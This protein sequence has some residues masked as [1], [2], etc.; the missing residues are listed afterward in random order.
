M[1]DCK[2]KDRDLKGGIPRFV[3]DGRWKRLEHI[4]RQE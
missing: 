1:F 4:F 3:F 2:G